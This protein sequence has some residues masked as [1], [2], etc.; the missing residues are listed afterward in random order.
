MAD[1]SVPVPGTRPLSHPHQ[2][3]ATPRTSG[4]KR[5]RLNHLVV[6]LASKVSYVGNIC[7]PLITC[8]IFSFMKLHKSSLKVISTFRLDQAFMLINS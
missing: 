8:L 4:N 2:I 5:P 6:M 3:S 7:F 1:S